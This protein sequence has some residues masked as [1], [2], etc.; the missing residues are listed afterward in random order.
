MIKVSQQFLKEYKSKTIFFRLVVYTQECL[1]QIKLGNI[2]KSFKINHDIR[3][4]L[5][6]STKFKI[7]L[8]VYNIF[9]FEYL[10]FADIEPN[11]VISCF[12][13][14]ILWCF[15]PDNIF[16]F[17]SR[18]CSSFQICFRTRALIIKG[19]FVEN[20]RHTEI[21]IYSYRVTLRN[22]RGLFMISHIRLKP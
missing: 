16:S 1:Y 14:N 3:K 12:S 10:R 6:R 7:K 13:K 22:V 8:Y 5:N 20:V 9:Q 15:H 4:L 21:I 11:Y 2:F 17:S 19:L 18:V